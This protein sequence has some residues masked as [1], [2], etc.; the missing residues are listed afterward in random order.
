MNQ[1]I[2]ST[3]PFRVSEEDTIGGTSAM[4]LF[5]QFAR[6]QE[7]WTFGP[8]LIKLVQGMDLATFELSPRNLT[9][10]WLVYYGMA[11]GGTTNLSGKYHAKFGIRGWISR[12]NPDVVIGPDGSAS[13]VVRTNGVPRAYTVSHLRMTA[14]VR[15]A[16]TF[17]NNYPGAPTSKVVPR[18]RIA[19][20]YA[21]M[22]EICE[23]KQTTV[24]GSP[25]RSGSPG[26]K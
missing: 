10:I 12:N 11:T 17:G 15:I 6:V 19:H 9:I 8:R 26:R 16:F 23:K 3:I 2:Y 4:T 1:E 18:E 7:P 22:A 21:E 20:V 24:R 13:S 25:K 14:L 5:E